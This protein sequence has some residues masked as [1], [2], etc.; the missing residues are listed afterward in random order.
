MLIGVAIFLRIV[1]LGRPSFWLDEAASSMLARTDWHTFFHSLMHR[2]ANMALYYVL[3]RGWI[4]FGNS[5]AL[6]RTL[7][8]LFGVAGVPVM[9]QL[10]SSVFDQKTARI[11]ALLLSVHQFH[12]Q[13][14]QEARGYS[15]LVFLGLLSSHFFVGLWSRPTRTTWIAYILTSVLLI[16]AHMFGGWILLAQWFCAVLCRSNPSIK[17]ELARAACTIAVLASPL[18][19]VLLLLSSRSQLS[20]M[21]QHSAA[22][23]YR[24]LLDFSGNPGSSL[25]ILEVGLVL[26]SIMFRVRRPGSADARVS[27][28]FIWIWLLL[29]TV[30]V[31]LLSLRWPMLQSRYLIVSLPPFL[32]LISDGLA[33]LRSRVLFVTAT[34]AV[35]GFALLGVVSYLRGRSDLSHS[36]N[37]RDATRYIL[38]EA[39]SGDAVLFPYSAEEIPLREYQDR[40]AGGKQHIPVVPPKTDLELL[41]VEGSWTDPEVALTAAHLYSRIWVITALQP[42]ERSRQLHREL[43]RNFRILSR[44][45]FG[46]VTI[47]M[48][49]QPDGKPQ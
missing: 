2:Q 20:W 14:S 1:A 19:G 17:K 32:L 9:Y 28:N 22:S 21:N 15:L 11:S 38:S 35:L 46:F 34:M 39:T 5:E 36:D 24:V 45:T 10:A 40:F 30:V 18:A 25:F 29:P 6:I 13:Y 33:R 26:V 27:Y 42:N 23:F 47:Q 31:G 48:L 44:Q 16:Y 8:V 3:L 7:S 37:W 4:H 43:S 12:V 49:A 41:S